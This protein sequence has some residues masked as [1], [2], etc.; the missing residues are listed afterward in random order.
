MAA[1]RLG[2]V[3]KP[4]RRALSSG[5][6]AATFVNDNVDPQASS[7]A[8]KLQLRESLYALPAICFQQF[9]GAVGQRKER[10]E[11][12]LI[13][14]GAL[15]HPDCIDGRRRRAQ[16]N[17]SRSDFGFVLRIAILRFEHDRL[18]E[19]GAPSRRQYFI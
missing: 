6:L 16:K 7:L 12:D 15:R 19:L 1:P 14:S 17:L 11:L 9:L 4:T 13:E 8:L 18:A 3:G 5:A 10:A 2:P